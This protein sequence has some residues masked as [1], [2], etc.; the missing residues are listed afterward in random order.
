[1][2]LEGIALTMIGTTFFLFH[3]GNETENPILGPAFKIFSFIPLLTLSSYLLVWMNFNNYP[4]AGLIGYLQFSTILNILLTFAVVF[5]VLM[6]AFSALI[7]R[8]PF[9]RPL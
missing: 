3:V 7:G 4:T 2:V 8:N 5:A 6:T 9:D 1:M